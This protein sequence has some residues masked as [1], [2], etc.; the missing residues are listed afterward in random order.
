LV[1][2][3]LEGIYPLTVT[4]TKKEAIM[5]KVKLI[6]HETYQGKRKSEDVFAAVFLSNA[7]ALTPNTHD[8]LRDF[9][10]SCIE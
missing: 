1:R 7:A 8:P 9:I 3:Q 6:V 5:R 4:L 2:K 10:I